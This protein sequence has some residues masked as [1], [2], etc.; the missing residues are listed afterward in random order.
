MTASRLPYWPLYIAWIAFCAVL[1]MVLRGADDPSR[2]GDRIIP[3]E[4]GR[5]AVETLQARDP[6]RFRDYHAVHA[7]WARAGEGAPERRWV[8]LTDR[9]PHSGLREAVVVELRPDGTLLRI[10]K[11]AR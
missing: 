2:R 3:A 7:G 11:P 4:A 6:E 8:V 1:F 9:V 5:I 10:R